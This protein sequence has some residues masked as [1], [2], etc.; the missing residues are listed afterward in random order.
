MLNHRSCEV[1]FWEVAGSAIEVEV[2]AKP[3]PDQLLALAKG[4]VMATLPYDRVFRA[5]AGGGAMHVEA[6]VTWTDGERFVAMP[7]AATAL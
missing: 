5:S 3:E 7:A 2:M 4:L 1:G 6:Q